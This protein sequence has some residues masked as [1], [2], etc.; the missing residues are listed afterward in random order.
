MVEIT[1]DETLIKSPITLPI[2]HEY[3]EKLDA[4]LQ[5][6]TLEEVI[7]EKLRAILQNIQAFERKGWVRSRARDYY[8]LWRILNTYKESLYLSNFSALLRQKCQNRDVDFSDIN[9]FF[10]PRLLAEVEKTWHQWLQPLLT[11]L[12]PYE[13]V[14]QEL[15][16][17]VDSLL[18]L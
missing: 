11:F 17:R 4:V 12:P 2:I 6:Y 18:S 9:S 13:L 16:H 15:R 1:R 7:A 8:D 14:I 5:V 10:S 3:G